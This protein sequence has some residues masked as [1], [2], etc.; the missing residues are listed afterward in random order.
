METFIDSLTPATWWL[1][2][3]IGCIIIEL[4]VV[5]TLAFFF[6]ATAAV[7]VGILIETS[8]IASD[9]LTVQ[10]AAFFGLTFVFGI[11]LWKPIKK[12]RTDPK[13]AKSYNNMVGGSVTIGP[14]DLTR[15]KTGSATWSG[16]TMRAKLAD[17]AETDTLKEGDT[18]TIADV[19]GN[20]LIVTP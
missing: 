20:V 13:N 8:T 2:V 17:D 11:A 16:A 10:L 15:G 6:A 19:L 7:V 5:S 14:G 9:D 4:F 1:V 18:A 12:W 3:A